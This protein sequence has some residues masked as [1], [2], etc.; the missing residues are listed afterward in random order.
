[1]SIAYV[2]AD[3]TETTIAL[4]QGFVADVEA[5]WEAPIERVAAALRTRADVAHLAAEYAAAGRAAGSLHAALASAYPLRPARRADLRRWRED[6]EAVLAEALVGGGSGPATPTELDL[7]AA[8][9][10]I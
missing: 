5:G 8:A 6:A 1:G 9:P 7:A 10:A 2:A 4:L 3:G